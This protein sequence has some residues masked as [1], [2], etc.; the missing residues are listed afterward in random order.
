MYEEL[1]KKVNEYIKAGI[2]ALCP[3]FPS[4]PLCIALFMAEKLNK[5]NLYDALNLSYNCQNHNAS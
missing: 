3:F 5:V 1:L 4:M 2:H